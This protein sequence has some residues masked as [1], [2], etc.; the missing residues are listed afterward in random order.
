MVQNSS[1]P[2]TPVS[3]N[4]VDNI[5]LKNVL[6]RD[7]NKVFAPDPNKFSKFNKSPYSLAT[8][9]PL[10]D[11]YIVRGLILDDLCQKKLKFARKFPAKIQAKISRTGLLQPLH[12]CP[13]ALVETKWVAM[14]SKV[15]MIGV[16][17]LN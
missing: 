8:E 16:C 15:I 12:K 5:D 13:R 3:G 10:P 14:G 17:N 7:Q 6:V 4:T 2:L 1:I 9:I 11:E